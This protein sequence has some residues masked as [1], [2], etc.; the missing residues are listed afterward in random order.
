MISTQYRPH[1][2]ILFMCIY[3]NLYFYFYCQ[4]YTFNIRYLS[5][6]YWWLSLLLWSFFHLDLIGSFFQ[7]WELRVISVLFCPFVF[8]DTMW[9]RSTPVWECLFQII[10]QTSSLM[11][12]FDA[13]ALHTYI[14]LNFSVYSFIPFFYYKMDTIHYEE[15]QTYV[16]VMKLKYILVSTIG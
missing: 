1:K 12:M 13:V 7:C 11:I 15:K 6:S 16:Q 4:K 14:M 8:W 9:G 5:S 3:Y 2:Q 10:L